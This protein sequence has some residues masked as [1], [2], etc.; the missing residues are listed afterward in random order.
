[1]IRAT[2]QKFDR[3]IAG[4]AELAQELCED[5]RRELAQVIPDIEVIFG[6]EF[7]KP[8]ITLR[9]QAKNEW[10]KTISD[11]DIAAELGSLL[12]KL[13]EPKNFYF[14]FDFVFLNEE[15]TEKIMALT[16]PIGEKA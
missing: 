4:F 7:N 15:E 11:E 1:M 2:V 14:Q 9:S 10:S 6:F 8:V 16:R 12:N 13:L 5:L 3:V